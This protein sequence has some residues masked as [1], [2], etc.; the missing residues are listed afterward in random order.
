MAGITVIGIESV[1][2]LVDIEI[3]K[4]LRAKALQAFSDLKLETPVDIGRAR[5]SWYIGYFET[6]KD[7]KTGGS[8]VSI[9]TKKSKPTKIIITNGTDY[10]E[11]LNDGHSQQAPTKFIEQVMSRYF[12]EVTVEIIK[13]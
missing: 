6:Y 8:S 5:G 9:L 1:N 2:K 11:Y 13:N 7:A 10:I 12:D 3:E 4:E